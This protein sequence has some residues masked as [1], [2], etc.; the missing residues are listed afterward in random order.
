MLGDLDRIVQSY[1]RALSNRGGVI[2]TTTANA[3]ANALIKRNPSV[4]GDIDANSS[5]WVASLFRRMGFVKRR[6]TSSKVDILDGARKEIEFL[7]HHD[8]VS[9]VEEFN[10]PETLI[11]NIDQTPLKYVP[12]SKETMAKRNSTSVTT[13]GS[14]DK[15]MITGTF[16]VTLGGNFLPMQLIYGGKTNQNIPR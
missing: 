1:L 16:A 13:E 14:D 8:I 4:V 7:F 6:K 15:R 3:T 12:V 11:I 9:G 10:I 2:S 5:R